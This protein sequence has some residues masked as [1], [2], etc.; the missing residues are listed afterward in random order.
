MSHGIT[1]ERC[2]GRRAT[3]ERET[4]GWLFLHQELYLKSAEK[5]GF[6]LHKVFSCTL[7]PFLDGFT[8]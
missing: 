4:E 6:F 3:L 7:D 8:V 1:V 5:S 2:G